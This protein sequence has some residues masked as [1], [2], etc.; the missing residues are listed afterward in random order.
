VF[1]NCINL[2]KTHCYICGSFT[3]KAQRRIITRDFQKFYLLNNGCSLGYQEKDWA[4]HVLC[5]SCSNGLRDWMHKRKTTVSFAISMTWQEPKNHVGDCYFRC[6]I[7]TGFSGKNKLKTVCHNVNSTITPI[8]HDDNL[9]VPQ[10][11]ENGQAFLE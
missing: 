7:V 3:A 2:P 11:P 6:L 5:T 1:G 9:R 8:P 4:P 10:P